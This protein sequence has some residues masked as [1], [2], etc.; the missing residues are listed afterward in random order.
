MVL[1]EGDW[2]ETTDGNIELVVVRQ[3]R[4]LVTL[5]NPETHSVRPDVDLDSI[6]GCFPMVLREVTR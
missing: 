2:V 6:R 3:T 1:I 5:Y 4:R